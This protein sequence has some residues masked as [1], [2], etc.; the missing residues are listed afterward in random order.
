MI[1]PLIGAFDMVARIAIDDFSWQRLAGIA[2]FVTFVPYGAIRSGLAGSVA[3]GRCSE[4]LPSSE[5]RFFNQ[6]TNKGG[7][8][9]T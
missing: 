3:L 4:F 7:G 5:T 9:L 2:T 1:A 8:S 6:Q